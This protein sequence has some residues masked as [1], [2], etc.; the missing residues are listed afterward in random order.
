MA[1]S[2]PIADMLTAIR[3]GQQVRLASINCPSSKIKKAILEVL[4][5]EGYIRSYSEE[6]IRTGVKV[7]TIDL[8]YYEGQPVIKKIKRVSKL[9]LR[10]YS[11]ISDL[12]KVQNGLGISILSTSKGVMADYEARQANIGGEI[13]C[14][15]F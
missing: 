10:V 3:N 15:V 1:L 2:D 14:N 11:S 12:P 9:G 13:I 8:K 6:E 5:K 4:I 7:L